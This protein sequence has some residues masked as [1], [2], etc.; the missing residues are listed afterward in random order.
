MSGVDL[1]PAGKEQAIPS[2]AR[3]QSVVVSVS[4]HTV[5]PGKDQEYEAWLREIVPVAGKAEGQRE[6]RVIR[7]HTGSR[8]YTIVLHFDALEHLEKWLT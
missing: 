6:M 3:G 8:T 7:P 4:R 2:P 5:L 1:A